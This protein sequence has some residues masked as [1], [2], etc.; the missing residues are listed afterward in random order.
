[1]SRMKTDEEKKKEK[2]SFV[3]G[4]GVSVDTFYGLQHA[5]LDATLRI[6]DQITMEFVHYLLKHEGIFVGPSAAMNAL[7]EMTPDEI[8]CTDR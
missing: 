3:E 5:K 1:M 6:D 8:V 7:G 4:I 2:P